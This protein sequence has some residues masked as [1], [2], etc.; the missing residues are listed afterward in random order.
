MPKPRSRWDAIGLATYGGLLGMLLAMMEQFCHAFCPASWHYVP[1]GDLFEHVLIEVV[2][3]AVAGAALL[4]GIAM[5]R[6][7]LSRET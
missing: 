5:I 2:A 3:F 6:N 1:E 7:W 4:A